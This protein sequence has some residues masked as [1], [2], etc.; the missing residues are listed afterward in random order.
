MKNIIDN[1]AS[2]FLG[3]DSDNNTI[4]AYKAPEAVDNNLLVA[5]PRILNREAHN[6]DD[7]LFNGYDSWNCYEISTMNAKGRPF[8]GVMKIFFPSD[9][10]NIVESKSLKLYLNSFNLVKLKSISNEELS[11][12]FKTIVEN[13]LREKI[14]DNRI[15]VKISDLNNLK[16]ENLPIEDFQNIDNLD[17]SIDLDE[18]YILKTLSFNKEQ[19]LKISSNLLRSNCRVTNQPDWGDVFI[20]IKGQSLPTNESLLSY[21]I[22]MRKEQHFHEEICETIFNDIYKTCL[23]EELIIKCFYTRRGGIDINPIRYTK[24]INNDELQKYFNI[25]TFFKTY[26]Q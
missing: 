2:K 4:S 1:I 7:S 25:D 5:I 10:I 14:E 15:K 8:V 9:S 26:R 13:N 16:V 20:Y 18:K 11:L 22:S 3:K 17:V 19:I 24:N 6:I 21:I 12:E 23:P